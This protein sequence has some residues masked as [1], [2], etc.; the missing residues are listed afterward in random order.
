MAD[1][2]EVT[3]LLA[4]RDADFVIR[5]VA[6]PYCEL[7]W[8]PKRPALRHLPVMHLPDDHSHSS[9]PLAARAF[10]T[11]FAAPCQ[12]GHN[13]IS[14]RDEFFDGVVEA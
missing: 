7:G 4:S 2:V 9:E 13:G 8:L 14:L 6:K 3:L 5:S 12:T 1:A 11:G 10:S